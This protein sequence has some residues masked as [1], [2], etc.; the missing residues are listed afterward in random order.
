MTNESIYA[1]PYNGDFQGFSFSTL[2]EYDRKAE[3]LRKKGC[4]E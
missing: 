4:E 1:Q 2:E 3:S